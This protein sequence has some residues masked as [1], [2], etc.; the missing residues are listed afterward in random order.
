MSGRHGLL[1]GIVIGNV[2]VG[3]GT[4]LSGSSFCVHRDGCDGV[5]ARG[6]RD[7]EEGEEAEFSWDWAAFLL[8]LRVKSRTLATCNS[9][10]SAHDRHWPNLGLMLR[11]CGTVSRMFP[12]GTDAQF[13]LV[14]PS[15]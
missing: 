6:V 10:S 3:W 13:R 8:L 5:G 12:D 9:P 11:P 2:L 14:Y 15:H 4:A 1:R 7:E